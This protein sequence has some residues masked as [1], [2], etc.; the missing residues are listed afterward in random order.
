MF[1]AVKCRIVS[2]LIIFL[3]ISCV[4]HLPAYHYVDRSQ[5]HMSVPIKIIPIYIDKD[6][7]AGDLLEIDNAIHQ[8]NYALNGYI[9][10]E[11]VT[12]KF[13]METD[14][15]KSVQAGEGW[16]I[17]KISSDS[18]LIHEKTNERTLAFCNAVG[19]Y[20]LFV[21]RD[22]IGNEDMLGV[23]L[24][25]IGHLL[26][27][28]HTSYGLMYWSYNPDTYQC[29][30]LPAVT[31]VSLYRGIPEGRMNFCLPGKAD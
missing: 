8:W 12:T 6:F 19:G 9:D 13:A 21:I 7:G 17:L 10:L 4:H 5:Y 16:L 23:M 11:I 20:V 24:H 18:P 26:G 14:I 1:K 25:E 15:I 22:R 28:S 30:D 3:I 2:S 31:G 29:I 27:A